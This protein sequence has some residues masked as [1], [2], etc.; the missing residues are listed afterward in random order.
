VAKTAL[1]RTEECP[2]NGMKAVI[3]EGGLQLLLVSS[4]EAYYGYQALCPHMDVPLEE[5]FYDGAVLTCHQHL[6]QWDI[7][8]GQPMGDAEEPLA[9][10]E[11]REEDGTLYLVTP[12]TTP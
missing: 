2:K 9:R 5:G 4:G 1:C 10:H 12:E 3:A 7:H 6:W 11:V 8:T